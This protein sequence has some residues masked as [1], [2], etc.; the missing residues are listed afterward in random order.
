MTVQKC[1]A[2]F[3]GKILMPSGFDEFLLCQNLLSQNTSL[4]AN[5]CDEACFAA[6]RAL[7]TLSI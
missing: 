5:G 2:C 7:E 1:L 6:V 3:H 4:Q